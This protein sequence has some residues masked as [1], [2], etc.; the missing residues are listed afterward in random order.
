M[1]VLTC[2]R[3]RCLAGANLHEDIIVGV[4]RQRRSPG[5]LLLRGGGRATRAFGYPAIVPT[6][7]APTLTLPSQSHAKVIAP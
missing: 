1:L 4:D 5:T 2:E 6:L 7:P 3:G